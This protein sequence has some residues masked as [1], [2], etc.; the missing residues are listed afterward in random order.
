MSNT[1]DIRRAPVARTLTAGLLMLAGL[2]SG[3][4]QPPFAPSRPRTS[5]SLVVSSLSE[6]VGSTG[7]GA[8][9][10]IVGAGFLDG[11]GGAVV[12]FGGTY[13]PRVSHVGTTT[14][15]ATV[16]AHAAGLVDVVVSNPDG[17]LGR[18]ADAYTYVSPGSLDFN[19]E[20]EGTS[21]TDHVEFRFRFT[22]QANRLTAVSCGS[23]ATVSFSSAPLVS[24][25]EFAFSR[26]DGLAIFGRLV[27]A[28]D[29]IGT[30]HLSP[31]DNSEWSARKQ[32]VTR[33]AK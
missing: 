1:R 8:E 5:T 30:I 24:N 18:L 12:I 4:G 31:C 7:G 26:E 11:E 9:V 29:A 27:S 22:V 2:A 10:K 3:C 6:S 15:V 28:R 19:G 21:R 20:W 23:S 33:P 14:I 16:P 17:Q 32:P 13:S 25:G